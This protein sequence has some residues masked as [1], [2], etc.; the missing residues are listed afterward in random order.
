MRYILSTV[1][2]SVIFGGPPVMRH[3]ATDPAGAETKIKL[4][5]GVTIF[6]QTS[7]CGRKATYLFRSGKG[8]IAAYCE[9]HAELEADRIGKDL[10][11][12]TEQLL[13]SLHSSFSAI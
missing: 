1:N 7:D 8:P 2:M 4:L 3:Y 11:L 9:L 6:C 13:E 5:R 10:P 12:D